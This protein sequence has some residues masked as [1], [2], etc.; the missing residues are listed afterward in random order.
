MVVG[1]ARSGVAAAELLVRRGAR[2]MLTDVRPSFE[3]A[4]GLRDLG[5]FVV[6]GLIAA[7]LT[8]VCR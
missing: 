5:V 8:Q 7:S 3:Q 4:P 6:A 1:A 2:V